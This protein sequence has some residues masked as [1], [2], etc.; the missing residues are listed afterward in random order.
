MSVRQFIFKDSYDNHHGTGEGNNCVAVSGDALIR[1]TGNGV[2]VRVTGVK[3]PLSLDYSQLRDLLRCA[4]MLDYE[5]KLS[6]QHLL[7][8]SVMYVL[9]DE[10]K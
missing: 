10:G 4:R 3:K 2:T 6:G 9:A 1:D 7:D 8:G 5:Q